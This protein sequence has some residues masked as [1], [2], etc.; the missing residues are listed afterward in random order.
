MNTL[1]RATTAQ[2]FTDTT[3]YDALR[4]HWRALLCSDRKHELDGAHH[5]LYLALLGKDWRKGFT[6]PSNPR[7]LANGALAGWALF[8]ALRTLHSEVAEPA[9]LAPFE[10]LVTPQM[11]QQLRQLLPL[12]NPL[13]SRPEEFAGGRFPFEAYKSPAEEGSSHA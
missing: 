7:K 8:R 1:S 9:L 2:W 6:P 13:V 11:L 3:A 12:P 5:L 4:A 10:G